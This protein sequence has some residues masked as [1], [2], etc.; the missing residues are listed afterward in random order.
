[1][2]GLASFFFYLPPDI[3]SPFFGLPPLLILV[4]NVHDMHSAL[5]DS[6]CVGFLLP[7]L[8]LV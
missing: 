4:N 7:G 1:M 5:C 3:L 8:P 2:L 6:H